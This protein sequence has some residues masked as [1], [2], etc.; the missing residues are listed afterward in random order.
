M[1]HGFSV[2]GVVLADQV[3]SLDW[4][5]RECARIGGLPPQVVARVLRRLS[6]LLDERNER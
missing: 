3:K 5:G 2:T 1:R 6:T 4:V